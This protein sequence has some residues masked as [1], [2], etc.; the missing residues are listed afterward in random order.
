MKLTHKYTHNNRNRLYIGRSYKKK[1]EK[2][3]LLHKMHMKKMTKS[4]KNI[5]TD[6]IQNMNGD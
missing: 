6:D 1:D 2:V 5:N 3:Y 4:R